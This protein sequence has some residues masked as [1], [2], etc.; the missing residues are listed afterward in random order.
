MLQQGQVQK[1]L[2]PDSW[3]EDIDSEQQTPLGLKRTFRHVQESNIEVGSLSR[4]QP[5]SEATVVL[6][7]SIVD[8][9]PHDLSEGEWCQI[10]QSALLADEPDSFRL[11][12]AWT[13]EINGKRVLLFSG[14]WSESEMF[15]LT[16]A[17]KIDH[18]LQ[19]IYYSAPASL[20]EKFLPA[21]EEALNSITWKPQ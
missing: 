2:L 14:V 18:W 6:F 17:T 9:A 19:L 16:L 7:N 3:Y 13:A 1:M 12:R 15:C 10:E 20:Y 21:V 4:R 5:L 11:I 8:S